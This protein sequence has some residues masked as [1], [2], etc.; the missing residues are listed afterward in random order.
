MTRLLLNFENSV[1]HHGLRHG[2]VLYLADGLVAVG[3]QA[4]GDEDGGLFAVLEA[5]LRASTT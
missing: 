1:A 2:R 4:V 5:A 3:V